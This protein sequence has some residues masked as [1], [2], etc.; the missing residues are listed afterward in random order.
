MKKKIVLLLVMFIAMVLLSSCTFGNR[1]VGIDFQQS[2]DEAYI[3]SL[4]GSLVVHGRIKN[5]RDFSGSDV[6]QITI[7]TKTYLTHYMNVIMIRDEDRH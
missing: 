7:G 3:Y 1:Q 4:D 2:F 5:Y 6:V